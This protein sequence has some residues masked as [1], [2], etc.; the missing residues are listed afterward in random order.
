[1][2]D[3]VRK[4][5]EDL[6]KHEV[7][8]FLEC[9]SFIQNFKC[10]LYMGKSIW[11]EARNIEIEKMSPDSFLAWI[12][13]NQSKRA[14]RKTKKAF[15]KVNEQNRIEVVDFLQEFYKNNEDS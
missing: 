5:W 13:Q 3:S 6:S 9:V 4:K 11:T 1:M 2:K 12:K 8:Q 7:Q 10:P 14:K 15:A